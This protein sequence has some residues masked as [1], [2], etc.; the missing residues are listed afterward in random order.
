MEHSDFYT[1]RESLVDQFPDSSMSGLNVTART[2]QYGIV[3]V[4]SG[5]VKREDPNEAI[6]EHT[7]ELCRCLIWPCNLACTTGAILFCC[8]CFKPRH[9]KWN[10]FFEAAVMGLSVTTNNITR[11]LCFIRLM[12]DPPIASVPVSVNSDPKPNP[13][14]NIL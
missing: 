12:T 8:C 5:E 6:P 9:P 10:R 3:D 7:C 11:C 4:E 13:N 2:S 14:P 1:P